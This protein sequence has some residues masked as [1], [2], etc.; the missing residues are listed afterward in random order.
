MLTSKLTIIY[1]LADRKFF[2]NLVQFAYFPLSNWSWVRTGV[3]SGIAVGRKKVKRFQITGFVA[4]RL[5]II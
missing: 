5:S 4:G 1:L 3:F 2:I